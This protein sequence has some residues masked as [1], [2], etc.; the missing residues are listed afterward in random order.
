MRR[1]SLRF[2]NSGFTCHNRLYGGSPEN[3]LMKRNEDINVGCKRGLF[4]YSYVVEDLGRDG[5]TTSRCAHVH[6]ANM[7]SEEWCPRVKIL[8]ACSPCAP[9]SPANSKLSTSSLTKSRH[10]CRSCRHTPV[11]ARAER[12]GRNSTTK[13]MT[14]C[15]RSSNPGALC[16]SSSGKSLHV[17]W[18]ASCGDVDA[19]A[20]GA[21]HQGSHHHH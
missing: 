21:A 20:I 1:P 6:V 9:L 8:V 13:A 4:Q 15:G 14:V 18:A 3:K 7:A 16:P 2:T 12:D 19:V 5:R 17:S 10:T 11:T